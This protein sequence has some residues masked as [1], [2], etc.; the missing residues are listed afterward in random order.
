MTIQPGQQVTGD[1]LTYATTPSTDYAVSMFVFSAFDSTHVTAH[2]QA[3][4]NIYQASGDV[5]SSASIT[6]VGSPIQSYVFL[7]GADVVNTSS[8]GAVVAIG[9]SITD[10]SNTSF[11]TKTNRSSTRPPTDTEE[12]S[13]RREGHW[14]PPLWD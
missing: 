14:R 2:R 1:A 12:S 8:A 10:G 7:T 11:G 5:S 4:Q 3:W 13:S 6:P 9:A